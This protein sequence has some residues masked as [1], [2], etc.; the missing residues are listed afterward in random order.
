MAGAG[1]TLSAGLEVSRRLTEAAARGNSNSKDSSF[2]PADA[3][4]AAAGCGG[5]HEDDVMYPEPSTANCRMS[6]DAF[7]VCQYEN[8]CFD[9][10][11][12]FRPDNRDDPPVLWFI[13]SD[14]PVP[15]VPGD[16]S[17]DGRSAYRYRGNAVPHYY[18][19]GGKFDAGT[20]FWSTASASD[21]EGDS[22]SDSGDVTSTADRAC[23]HVSRL[24]PQAGG[25][26]RDILS[27]AANH[28]RGA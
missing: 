23:R 17:S 14:V 11:G 24:H 3:A 2:H 27:L 25:S 12:P 9:L 28:Q 10:P 22:T 16:V 5:P 20:T 6:Q 13:G 19:E 21:S 8:V 15:P 26:N 7:D 18:P 4:A 1:G